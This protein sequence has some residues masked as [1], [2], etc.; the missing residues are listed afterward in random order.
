MAQR[1][2]GGVDAGDAA[3]LGGERVAGEVH[4]ESVSD[5]LADEPCRLQ[6]AVPPAMDRLRTWA[7]LRVGADGE[8]LLALGTAAGVDLL[9]G[10]QEVVVGLGR[11]ANVGEI[12]AQEQLQLGEDRPA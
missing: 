1:L 6:L 3:E 11:S 2:R 12:A 10:M 7:L 9:G 8:L 5:P 4:V